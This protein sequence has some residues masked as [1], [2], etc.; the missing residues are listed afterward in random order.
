LLLILNKNDSVSSF[1][2]ELVSNE[3]NE[4]EVSDLQRKK[5]WTQLVPSGMTL[6]PGGVFTSF[7][8]SDSQI[9]KVYYIESGSEI[10]VAYN[11]EKLSTIKAFMLSAGYRFFVPR[12]TTYRIW[13]QSQTEKAVLYCLSVTEDEAQKEWGG[14][15][16][17]TSST[18]TS[19]RGR[20]SR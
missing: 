18:K 2:T 11:F 10:E 12:G 8:A 6:L 4:S 16:V 17:L 15:G 14:E 20:K 9:H 7:V 1:V 19:R 3:T 13:N 5:F